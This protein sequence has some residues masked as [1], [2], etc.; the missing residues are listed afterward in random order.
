MWRGRNIV[1]DAVG[2][3]VGGAPVERD[4]V[5]RRVGVWV[6][7]SQSQLRERREERM[8]G[9]QK[10]QR[11]EEEEGMD[12]V[13]KPP[14]MGPGVLVSFVVGEEGEEYLRRGRGMRPW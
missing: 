11:Q 7:G 10:D 4:L 12:S 1:V 9:I 5:E 2:W 13:M 8:R 14:A 3:G 6:S